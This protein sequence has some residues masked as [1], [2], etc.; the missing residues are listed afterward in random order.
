M[1]FAFVPIVIAASLAVT[2]CAHTSDQAATLPASQLSVAQINAE[3]VTL[4]AQASALG[5]GGYY[6]GAGLVHASTEPAPA[7]FYV[8]DSNGV[9]LATP[10]SIAM[11]RPS[12]SS[13]A[14][15]SR[16][17]NYVRLQALAKRQA[18]LYAELSERAGT[19]P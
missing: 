14:S 17:F 7:Q 9:P 19:R 18:E 13:Y 6:P 16:P 1:K 11:P 10:L 2:A 12:F 8:S 15:S 4:S 5:Q 3:I